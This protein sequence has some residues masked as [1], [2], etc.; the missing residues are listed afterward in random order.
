MER[1]HIPVPPTLAPRFVRCIGACATQPP[2]V[3][4]GVNPGRVRRNARG[5]ADFAQT[6]QESRRGEVCVGG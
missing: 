5:P 4:D 3:K 2:L 6:A 1:R